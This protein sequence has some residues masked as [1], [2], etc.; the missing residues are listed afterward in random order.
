MP[1]A[2]QRTRQNYAHPNSVTF[3]SAKTTSLRKSST[4]INHH[5]PPL[6]GKSWMIL[7][8]LS[9]CKEF[10]HVALLWMLK[11]FSLWLFPSTTLTHIAGGCSEKWQHQL[12]QRGGERRHFVRAPWRWKHWRNLTLTGGASMEDKKNNSSLNRCQVIITTNGHLVRH[13]RHLTTKNVIFWQSCWQPHME[14]N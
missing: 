2:G 6:F 8:H 12:S 13:S 9:C 1:R 7:G 11:F 10:W 3:P 4:V 5:H 14:K